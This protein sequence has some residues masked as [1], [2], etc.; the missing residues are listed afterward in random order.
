M[1]V[2]LL[3]L[4][5]GA[6]FWAKKENLFQLNSSPV[7]LERE[8]LIPF[9][10]LPE[11][12][13][14][15]LQERTMVGQYPTD[16]RAP[17]GDNPQTHYV[18]APELFTTPEYKWDTLQNLYE[19]TVENQDWRFEPEFSGDLVNAHLSICPIGLGQTLS[20]MSKRS[21]F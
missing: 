16:V 4:A 12:D 5:G 2:A 3:F 7:S 20:Y 14:D 10:K 1:A 6:L 17:F 9:D 21:N 19:L 15:E 11:W 13:Q 8:S 18:N